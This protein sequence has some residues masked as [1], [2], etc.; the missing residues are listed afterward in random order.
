MIKILI[1][2]RLTMLHGTVKRMILLD[3]WVDKFRFI[4]LYIMN[5]YIYYK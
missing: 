5:I 2:Q 1:V 3:S 4:Y